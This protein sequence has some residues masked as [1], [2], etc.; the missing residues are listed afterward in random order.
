MW[1]KKHNAPGRAADS[2]A[3]STAGSFDPKESAVLIVEDN[4]DDAVLEARALERFG[5]KHIF[6][7]ETAEDALTFASQQRCDAAL[8]DYQ[9]PGMDGLRFVERLSELS[10]DTRIIFVTGIRDEHVAVQAMKLGASDYI[11]K[12]EL[13]TSGIVRSLQTALR[14]GDAA[15]E[16]K[17]E[18]LLGSGA[19]ELD[20]AREEIDWVLESLGEARLSD[21]R[22]LRLAAYEEQGRKTY[23]DVLGDYSPLRELNLEDQGLDIVLETFMRYLRN[24]FRDF[25]E[26]A[27]EQ[28]EQLARMLMT[29]GT[30][31]AQVISL[32]RTALGF[33]E[34]E[35]VHPAVN[36]ALCLVRVFADIIEQYHFQQSAGATEKAT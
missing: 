8:I 30:S 4:P 6:H 26:P 27:T 33:L 31:P 13:L 5:I 14:K 16:E 24:T 17:H 23:P 2:H 36:P 20:G 29:R 7:A 22:T 11:P 18:Q 35:Q 28:G 10:P 1:A 3:T 12:D 19:G 32:Y 15:R 25:P 21:A 9:L 34:L